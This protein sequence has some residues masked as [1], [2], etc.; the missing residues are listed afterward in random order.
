MN[1]LKDNEFYKST[2][3]DKVSK[4]NN[5]ELL[6]IIYAFVKTIADKESGDE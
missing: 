5:T 4:I 3:A 6:S 2:I 1:N